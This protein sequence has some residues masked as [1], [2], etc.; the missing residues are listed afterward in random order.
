MTE[1]A[2]GH[3]QRASVAKSH[4]QRATVP[5]LCDVDGPFLA[6]ASQDY[7]LMDRIISLFSVTLI[8]M[9]LMELWNFLC[10]NVTWVLYCNQITA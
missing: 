8:L 3:T 9:V 7:V 1:L 2:E 4:A 10:R 6:I 5:Y